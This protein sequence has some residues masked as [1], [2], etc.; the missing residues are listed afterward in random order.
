VLNYKIR[1][2]QITIEHN[3]ITYSL[4]YMF[5]PHWIIS[6]LTFWNMLKEVYISHCARR[7]RSLQIYLQYQ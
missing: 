2:K 7:S 3:F 6:R 4:S 5:R 1:N